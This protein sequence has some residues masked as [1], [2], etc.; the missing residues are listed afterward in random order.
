MRLISPVILLLSLLLSVATCGQT[1]PLY[2]PE[3]KPSARVVDPPLARTP[4]EPTP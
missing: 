1:G 4:T 3:E 2:L